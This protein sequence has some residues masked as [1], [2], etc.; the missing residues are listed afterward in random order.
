MK[1]RIVFILCLAG[2]F[3][4]K[5]TAPV[6]DP[7]IVTP[8]V[9]PPAAAPRING[10]TT[11]TNTTDREYNLQVVYFVP[12][13]LE[14]IMG[15]ETRLSELMLWGQNWYKEK[16]AAYGYDKTF[17]LYTDADKKKVRI[18]TVYGSKT[19]AEYTAEGGASPFWKETEDY[20]TANPSLRTSDHFIVLIPRFGFK[21]TGEPTGGPYYGITLGKNRLCFVLDYEDMDLKNMSD[22]TDKG[23]WCRIYYGGLMHELG[24]ALNL[25][26][27]VHTPAQ[28]ADPAK[29]T[30]LMSSGNYTLGAKPTFLTPFDC[31]LLNDCQVMNK[32]NSVYYG[33][34][35]ASLTK[36]EGSYDP[37]KGAIILSGQ[38][39]SS[40][41]VNNIGILNDPNVNNEGTGVNHDYNAVG[42]ATKPI[43]GNSFYIEMPVIDFTYRSNEE[44]E[45]RIY[46]VHSNGTSTVRSYTYKFVNNLP[47]IDFS[48]RQEMA[49][50]GWVIAGF[51]S[52][53]TGASEGGKAKE[54]I[55]GSLN[56]FWH[57]RWSSNAVSYPHYL[58]IDMGAAKT[59]QGLSFTQRQALTRAVKDFEILVSSDGVT[60]T[61]LGN[62]VATNT[63]GTQ[64]FGFDAPKTF[65][66]F[67]VVCNSSWD[68]AQYAAI[69]E[70][71][72]Y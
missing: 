1:L 66:Y 72:L 25:P 22:Q 10:S 67:K 56:T 26:H 71:G 19:S 31:A 49:K 12:K 57:S 45:L 32:N 51:S 65:R 59:V 62:K 35:T 11:G 21:P 52:E 44:Y 43:G 27:N 14:P 69:A 38:F 9:I 37:G 8:P 68:G 6:V 60:F 42:Y 28:L 20:F 24:H 34:V 47:V 36:L 63:S 29:G 5:K 41:P 18:T 55:D 17:G 61:S 30:S 7:V 53:E 58:S 46:M 70:L 15:Y 40:L 54:V 13:D 4:C 33:A 2:F 50:T 48:P 3:A 16:M 64:Y 39:T 23:K